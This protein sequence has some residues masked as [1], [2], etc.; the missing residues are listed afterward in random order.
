MRG[1]L[2]ITFVFIINLFSGF[3]QNT[4]PDNVH[5]PKLTVPEAVFDFGERDNTEIVE[6]TFV[7]KNEGN[8]SLEIKNTRP[9]CGCT[10]AHLSG[11]IIPPG[12]SV[13]LTAK[14]TL[15]GRRGKQM[16][17]ILVESNDPD[18]PKQKL[19]LQGFAKA[20][21]QP[22]KPQRRHISFGRI[23]PE[24]RATAT[25]DLEI[26]Q[27]QEAISVTGVKSDSDHFSARLETIEEGKKYRVIVETQP[28]LPKGNIRSSVHILTGKDQKSSLTIPLFA[29]IIG[30]LIVYPNEITLRSDVEAPS[31][32]YIIIKPGTVTEFTVKDVVIPDDSI[33][34]EI[35]DRGTRGVRIQLK[36]MMAKDE[37]NG[38]K[39]KIITDVA[40]MNEIEIPIKILPDPK[41]SSS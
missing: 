17:T 30:E 20:K 14:L 19:V 38:Q 3:A 24:T 8:L 37:L 28:P 34:V 2:F 29:T 26:N 1:F 7:L 25:V 35:F 21:P 12:G 31:T 27:E 22:I 4:L 33:Q 5:A 9:S 40:G 11:K 39:I 13:T 23:P 32:R 41:A 16:K 6:H 10:V 36:N 15:K 18:N